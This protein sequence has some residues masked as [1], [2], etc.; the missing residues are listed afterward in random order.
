MQVKLP[1]QNIIK[2]SLRLGDEMILAPLSLFRPDALGL[3]GSHLI[4][5]QTRSE[6]DPD[7]PHDEDYLRRTQRQSQQASVIL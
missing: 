6:G 3:Q 2:Y 4:R 5:L 7:D 1:Q